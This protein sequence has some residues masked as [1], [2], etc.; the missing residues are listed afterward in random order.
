MT[1]PPLYSYAPPPPL[2]PSDQRLWATLIQVGGILFGI[3]PSLIGFLVTKDRGDF[4][5]QHTRAALN[6]QITLLLAYVACVLLSFII[7]GLFLLFAVEIVAIIF[8]ILAAV[9]ANSG[10]AYKFPISIEFVK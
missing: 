1:Q 6:F 10:Q 7:I 3:L 2:S 8:G 5:R 4:I 9:A